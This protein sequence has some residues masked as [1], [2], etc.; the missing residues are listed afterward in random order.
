MYS[1]HSIGIY[2]KHEFCCCTR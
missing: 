1:L 2:V